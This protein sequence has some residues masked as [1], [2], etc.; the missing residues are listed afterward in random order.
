M[1]I[2]KCLQGTQEWLKL[3]KDFN[4][5]SEAPVMM[6]VSSYMTREELLLLKKTGHEKDVS[7]LEYIFNKGH[8]AEKKERDILEEM[9]GL[10][11]YPVVVSE[12]YEELELLASMDGLT[13]QCDVGLEHKL[14][15]QRLRDI[16]DADDIP[17]EY[18]I[19]MD[20][21]LFITKADFIYFVVSDGTK[22]NLTYFKYYPNESSFD[23]LIN[24]W[25]IFNKD[26]ETFEITEKEVIETKSSGSLPVLSIKV[27]GG[28]TKSNLSEF[29]KQAVYFLNNI[30]VDLR[31]DVDFA[32]AE[33]DLKSCSKSEDELISIKKGILRQTVDISMVF[34]TIDKL[35]E[36][37]RDKRLL[38]SKLIKEKKEFIKKGILLDAR[39]N[40]RVEVESKNELLRNGITLDYQIPDYSGHIKGKRALDSINRAINVAVLTD[41]AEINGQYMGICKNIDLYEKE[42]KGNEFLFPDLNI[43]V[44]KTE[45]DFNSY[46]LLKI[47][48]YKEGLR[49]KEK[50]LKEEE[51]LKDE[52]RVQE[53]IE[54]ER[55]QQERL[56]KERLDQEK[57][58][59]EVEEIGIEEIEQELS[60]EKPVNDI[61]EKEPEELPVFEAK[62]IGYDDLPEDRKKDTSD[63]GCGKE[64]ANYLRVTF[65]GEIV[66]I[67]SDAMEP[68]DASFS[69]DLSWIVS[70][71]EVAFDIG[72][73]E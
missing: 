7:G 28:V 71:L 31:E 36:D 43:L 30:S 15:N 23:R 6:G 50:K 51:R 47:S 68:E 8:E 60:I 42:F 26:L 61:S 56:E 39:E 2:H 54:K 55:Q 32:Q 22:K 16:K 69:R 20:Q 57:I 10:E 34:K 53:R 21:Q 44:K 24:G 33:L 38:L 41:K 37:F 27:K 73:R 29:E 1:K 58:E 66:C 35:K 25:R 49:L 19:Q 3:R 40:I 59:R 17:L 52:L 13:L 12:K 9:K 67:Y 62:I 46:C 48:Q 64:W 45:E 11:F 65:N 70:A 4:S 63:N 72:R 18:K 14:S 5:A